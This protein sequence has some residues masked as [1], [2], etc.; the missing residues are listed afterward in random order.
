M[1]N[2]TEGGSKEGVKRYREDY[3]SRRVAMHEYM[4][5]KPQI[6]MG[7]ADK[8]TA[9]DIIDACGHSTVHWTGPGAMPGFLA[10]V[11]LDAANDRHRTP[12]KDAAPRGRTMKCKP[13]VEGARPAARMSTNPGN[14]RMK[15]HA[16][17]RIASD[18]SGSDSN[19]TIDT[20]DLADDKDA[21]VKREDGI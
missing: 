5:S 14:G 7:T 4:A 6:N 16:G 2:N 12:R 20:R 13:R 9:K 1:D 18:D 3:V 11:T 19:S 8:V 15:K 21:P 17:Y 10:K